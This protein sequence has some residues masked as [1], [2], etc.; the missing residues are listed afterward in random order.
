MAEE[1]RVFT[2]APWGYRILLPELIGTFLPPRL[3]VPGFEWAA[4][5]S[6]VAVA[7]LLF[8]YLRILGGT[9]R[10]ALI[11]VAGT[12]FSPPV[13]AVFDNP[14]LVEPFAL[15]LLLVALIVIEG[16]GGFWAIALSLILLSLS[17]EIW[18]VLLPLI[19]LRQLEDETPARAALATA[20]VA[21]PSLW[22]GV[23]MRWMWSHQA[24]TSTTG[25]TLGTIADALMTHAGSA[26]IEYLLGGF[27]LVALFALR[28]EDARA[29]LRDR[30]VTLMALLVLPLAAAVYTGEGA[31]TSFFSADIRRLLIYV[32]PVIAGIAIHLDPNH[33]AARVFPSLPRKV[34]RAILAL[35]LAFLIAPRALIRYSRV[36]LSTTRDGP[37]VLGFVRETLKTA[38]KLDRGETVILDPAERRFAWG[39]SPPNELGKLRFFLRAGFGP[40]AHYGI[41]D[42]L[43]REPKAAIVVPVFSTRPVFLTLTLDARESAW[44]TVSAGGKKVGEALAGPQV[45]RVTLEVPASLIVPGDNLVELSCPTPA[46]RP[47]LLR[48]ELRQA[49]R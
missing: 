37:Y 10:A 38:R 48:V 22:V 20:A 25:S 47:R 8:V 42:V 32:L 16:R 21:T 35:V 15:A 31:A 27:T 12:L 17:K 39:V 34:Q 30:A 44:V 28:D 11:A 1:P 26:A 41:H 23:W 7:G 49:E 19:F 29:Y 33:G 13:A 43:M 6:L 45:V 2:V 3:I 4:R 18:I 46:V 36:D 24:A 40:L 14:F 5:A 9:M